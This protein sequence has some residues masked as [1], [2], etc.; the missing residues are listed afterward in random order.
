MKNTE[1]LTVPEAAQLISMTP[2]TIRNYVHHH[3]LPA[4]VLPTGT[5][6]I[7]REDF[8]GWLQTRHNHTPATV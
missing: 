8:E 1:W 3:A 2:N 6:R 5:I 7:R 4:I